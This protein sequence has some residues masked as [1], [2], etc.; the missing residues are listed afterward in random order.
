MITYFYAIQQLASK[1]VIFQSYLDIKAQEK[2]LIIMERFESIRGKPK[3]F[4]DGYIYNFHLTNDDGDEY[5]RCGKRKECKGRLHTRGTDSVLFVQHSG[6]VPDSA[7]YEVS[8]FSYDFLC[9]TTLSIFH[10]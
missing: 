8:Y 3:L 6:H 10:I 5:W 1:S 9:I 7:L 2:T 4:L